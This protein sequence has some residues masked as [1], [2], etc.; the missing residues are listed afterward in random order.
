MPTGPARRLIE[1]G[2]I[3]FTGLRLLQAGRMV[4]KV[5]KG[6][7]IGSDMALFVAADIVDGK[8]A[9]YFEADGPLRRT[10]DALVDRASVTKVS[11]ALARTNPAAMPYIAMLASREIAVSLMNATYWL[12][13]GEAVHGTEYHHLAPLSV[14]AFAVAAA[15]GDRTATHLTGLAMVGVNAA[16]ALDYLDNARDKGE[17]YSQDGVK[18]IPG[19]DALK[20]IF[21]DV[22]D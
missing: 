17:G 2:C 12:R 22:Q 16:L 13:T 4:K 18:H 7:A 19:F 14:S 9:R 10:A 11:L 8:I 20:R 5:K 21:Q 1:F 15:N 6:E 3:A